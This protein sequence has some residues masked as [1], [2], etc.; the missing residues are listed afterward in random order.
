MPV[1]VLK[2]SPDS[3]EPSVVD[4]A[5]DFIRRGRVVGM[6]TDTFYAL[7]ADPFNLSSIEHVFR[8]KGRAENKALPI[9][10]NSIEQAVTLARDLPDSFLVL[11]HKFWPGALTLVVEATH[12]L[13][14][15]VT[16]NTG[17][18]ALRWPDSRIAS[19][20]IEAVHGP[21]TGTSANLSG[22]PSCTNA[23]QIVKQLG[24]RLPLIL[25]S[26]D[27]GA[28]MASTIV[29]ISGNEWT[30]VREGAIPESEITAALQ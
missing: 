18:V 17:R 15:K 6:P 24:E 10:V 23:S 8:V 16:G 2:I 11:A 26:G 20:L 13:P 22:F 30:I 14:L 25:D 21:I 4:Y 7:S 29:R 27:T 12:R 28:I 19:A 1:E 5:A 3:P 9:L